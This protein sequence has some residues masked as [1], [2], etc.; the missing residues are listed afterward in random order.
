MVDELLMQFGPQT[1]PGGPSGSPTWV[2]Q[3]GGGDNVA[4]CDLN[5]TDGQ[6]HGGLAR[7]VAQWVY[8]AYGSVVTA[9]HLAPHA[10]LRC[11]HKSQFIDRLDVGVAAGG[12]GANGSVAHGTTIG[13]PGAN[14]EPPRLVPF[15]HA[16]HHVRNRVYSPQLG[17]W[18][19]GDP[20]ASGL[21]L[22]E[23]VGYHGRTHAGA[24][25][26]IN[27]QSIYGDGMS[28]Y[29]YLGA[30]PWQRSDPLGLEW[31]PFSMVDEYLG[32]H[33][34]EAGSFMKALGRD[35]VAL[36][37]IR[38]TIAS[39]LPFPGV[40]FAGE[41]GLALINGEPLD[42][43][44]LSAA[45]GFLPGGGL[46][47][48]L[49]EMAIGMATMDTT[50][51]HGGGEADA[52]VLEALSEFLGDGGGGQAQ[53]GVGRI[54]GRAAGGAVNILSIFE[55]AQGDAENCDVYVGRDRTGRVVYVGQTNNYPRRVA[56]HGRGSNQDLD[57]EKITT[58]QV[59]R[60][61]A[62][63][64]ETAVMTK[65][66]STGSINIQGQFRNKRRGIGP[67]RGQVFSG[68]LSWGS[69]WLEKNKA[70]LR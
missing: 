60:L 15:A 7:V 5:G 3:D 27:L 40:S 44:L 10:L 8:D 29:A 42:D 61:Q 6:G 41:V 46:V 25:A 35:A 59:S 47:H 31:D 68:A 34:A 39:Y 17:R 70:D 33:A 49:A 43:L 57:I 69:Q 13:T 32:A 23:S 48:F 52:E 22:M 14:A 51:S 54:V 37:T 65:H 67:K 21:T 45:I 28:L 64:I 11:G 30:N 20:N 66:G 63:A 12:V 55:N 38:A 58:K 4:L 18:L 2:L 19:Q 53:A 16:V 62:R 1:V 26:A 56:E 50:Y 24:A 36:A 9:E